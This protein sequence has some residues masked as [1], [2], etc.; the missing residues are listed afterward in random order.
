MSPTDIYEVTPSVAARFRAM[1]AKAFQNTQAP[2]P[3]TPKQWAK[4]VRRWLHTHQ[5]AARLVA[6]YENLTREVFGVIGALPGA[7]EMMRY[8]RALDHQ[9]A[10]EII[11]LGSKIGGE[12]DGHHGE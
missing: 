7:L 6:E 5:E 3:L 4:L 1:A 9:A 8:F 10:E 11:R 12:D 2:S